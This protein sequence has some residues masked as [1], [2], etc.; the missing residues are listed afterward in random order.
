MK[1]FTNSNLVVDVMISHSEADF[2]LE[3]KQE[4]LARRRPIHKESGVVRPVIVFFRSKSSLMTFYES[5]MMKK[6]KNAISII[7]ETMS[8]ETRDSLFLKATEHGSITLMIRDFGRGTDFKCFDFNLQHEGGVH[9]I[10]AFF[11]TDQSEEVQIKGR[12]ARHGANGSYR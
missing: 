5:D 7:D 8:K 11:S 9:V 2:L 10:Q 3:L 12:T 4:I 6:F 1:T